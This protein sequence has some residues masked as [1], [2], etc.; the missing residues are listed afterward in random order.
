MTKK[1]TAA[2]GIPKFSYRR[3]VEF[4]EAASDYR[5]RQQAPQLDAARA[6]GAKEEELKQIQE[7]EPN[8]KLYYA[9]K[10]VLKGMRRPME[11]HAEAIQDIN[12]EHAATEEK[13]G[14]LLMD[15]ERFRFTRDGM[16]ARLV[17]LRKLNEETEYEVEPYF[18]TEIP[19]DLTE[20]ELEAFSGF[21]LR[22]GAEEPEGITPD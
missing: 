8:T 14:A 18:A 9:I 6:R 12:V 3:I 4:Q 21:I 1:T 19:K 17:A 5:K 2:N 10:R 16:K 7:A 13:T 20:E 22:P 15:G 11:Q